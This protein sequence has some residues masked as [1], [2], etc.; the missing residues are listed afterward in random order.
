MKAACPHCGGPLEAKVRV[1]VHL[2]GGAAIPAEPRFVRSLACRRI[3][4]WLE[5]EGCTTERVM[6]R[7]MHMSFSECAK[8]VDALVAEGIVRVSGGQPRMVH[9]PKHCVCIDSGDIMTQNSNP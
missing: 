2:K 3:E 4:A 6:Y 5:R 8:T 7:K 1:N 9:W